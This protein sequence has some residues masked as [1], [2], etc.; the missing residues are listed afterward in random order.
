MIKNILSKITR[1]SFTSILSISV[2]RVCLLLLLFI[3]ILIM[4]IDLYV[5]YSTRNQIY[6]TIESVPTRPYTLVLGTSRYFSNKQ[7]NLFYLNR[8]NA[9]EKLITSGK[10][11][12][13]LLSGDN[14]TI[15]YNEPQLMRKDLIQLGIDA[16]R[17]HLDYAGFRT[18]D[19]MIRAKHIFHATPMII[20]SQRFHC[21]RA[22]FIAKFHQIDAICFAADYPQDHYKVR[23]REY[24]A[25]LY[26]VWDLIIDKTPYFMGDPEPLPRL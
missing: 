22:L 1:L 4:L 19:S 9:A 8:L 5:S 2:L 11:Q 16:E 25:R 15:Y 12:H 7:L 17:L 24:L 13:L 23:R 21:E 14:R 6:T 18:L 3:P 20:V 26:M 10:T